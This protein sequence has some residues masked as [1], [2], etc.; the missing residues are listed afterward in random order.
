MTDDDTDDDDQTWLS[1]DLG[2]CTKYYGETCDVCRQWYLEQ[3]L[4][5]ARED[6]HDRTPEHD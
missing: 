5:W 2:W 4:D 3:R 6:H 1:H